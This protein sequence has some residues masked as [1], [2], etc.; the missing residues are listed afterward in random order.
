MHYLIVEAPGVPD[1]LLV[2]SRR[3]RSGFFYLFNYNIIIIIIEKYLV[4]IHWT[5]CFKHFFVQITCDGAKHQTSTRSVDGW[6]LGSHQNGRRKASVDGVLGPVDAKRRP[7]TL[8]FT[9]WVGYGLIFSFIEIY[10]RIRFDESELEV[11]INPEDDPCCAHD[12]QPD[13]DG[14]T[15]EEQFQHAWKK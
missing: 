11:P 3:P 13:Q 2:G 4:L 7:V 14:N 12:N 6:L 8:Y 9:L 1:T 5:N 10:F 15:V